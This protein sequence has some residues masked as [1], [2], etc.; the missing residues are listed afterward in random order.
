MYDVKRARIDQLQNRYRRQSTQRSPDLRQT[1]EEYVD[2]L[3]D[4]IDTFNSGPGADSRLMGLDTTGELARMEEHAAWAE[5]ERRDVR[6]V[7]SELA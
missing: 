3:S 5:L 4:Y 1:A 7:L 6:R 2:A